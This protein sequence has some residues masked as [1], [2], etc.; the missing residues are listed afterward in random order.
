MLHRTNFWSARKV[1][2]VTFAQKNCYSAP[3]DIKIT[4]RSYLPKYSRLVQRWEGKVDFESTIENDMALLYGIMKKKNLRTLI[5]LVLQF[6]HPERDF[7]WDLRVIFNDATSLCCSPGVDVFSDSG[8]SCC[9]F[10]LEYRAYQGEVTLDCVVRA[11]MKFTSLSRV[12]RR[13]AGL[14]SKLA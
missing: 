4:Y 3:I 14:G 8:D 5:R 13:G 7:R 9:I 10:L 1:S 11:T 12:E 6:I 2:C